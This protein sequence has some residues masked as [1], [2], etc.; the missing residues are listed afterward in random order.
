MLHTAIAAAVLIVSA[1]AAGGGS[2]GGTFIL[3]GWDA[4]G[5]ALGGAA[6]LLVRDESAAHWNPANLVFLDAPQIGVGA[7]NPVPGLNAYSNVLTAGTGLLDHRSSRD[8]RVRV[9]RLAVALS[10]SRLGLELA[11][12]SRWNEGT[13]GVAAAFSINNHN[14]IGLGWRAMK[15]WTDLEDAGAWGNAFDLGFTTRLTGRIWLAAVARD[16]WSTIHYPH[17][18]EKIDPS[19]VL[20]GSFER[21]FDRFSTE[22]DVVLRAGELHSVLC[23][24][25]LT[26]LDRV[27][28]IQGGADVRMAYHSRTIPW[29]GVRAGYG[30]GAISLAFGFDPEDAFGRQTRVSLG[31]GF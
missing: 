17:R 30:G 10:F 22:I 16:G 6:A 1:P 20:A 18:H 24:A 5:Q 8:G 15:S 26:L 3:R 29:F 21:I 25:E 14:F 7:M 11:G 12:G 23:G 27:L 31:Y 13:A 9:R 19:L 2:R 4:R 28:A